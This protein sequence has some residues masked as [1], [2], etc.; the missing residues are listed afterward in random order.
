M[1]AFIA[2]NLPANIK[3]DIGEIIERIRHADPL[4]R[5]VPPENLHVT[6]KFLDEIRQDQ[7]R[8]IIGALTLAIGEHSSFELRLGGFGFFPNE[9]KAR[10]FWVGIESG[11]DTLK[12]LA[13]AIDHQIASLG[14][15]PETRPFSA[16]ITLARLREP[17]PVDRLAKAAAHVPYLSEPIPIT[18]MDLM[19]SV[20]SPNGASYSIVDSVHLKRSKN[21]E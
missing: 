16:H 19:R 18:Q 10:I 21:L 2:V 15:A 8:P 11:F 9:R 14:F 1:R 20:L 13:R 7:I 3:Q 4:A 17:G 12:S 6:V 5:W